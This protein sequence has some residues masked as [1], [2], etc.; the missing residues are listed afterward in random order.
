MQSQEEME[1]FV[2]TDI[3]DVMSIGQREAVGV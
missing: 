2:L 3:V 1:G